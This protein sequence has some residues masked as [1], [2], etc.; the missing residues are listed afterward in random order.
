M[1][2]AR[3]FLYSDSVFY[4]AQCFGLCEVDF[5]DVLLTRLHCSQ[6]RG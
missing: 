2:S 3:F 4:H 1:Y 5:K 6:G